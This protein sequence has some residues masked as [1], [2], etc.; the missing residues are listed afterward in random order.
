MRNKPF[1]VD[2][3]MLRPESN[4]RSLANTRDVLAPLSAGR[5]SLANRI[6][7]GRVMSEL[8]RQQ[9]DMVAS[10]LSY[11][12]GRKVEVAVAEECGK[13]LGKAAHNIDRM[14]RQVLNTVGDSIAAHQR[15][16]RLRLHRSHADIDAELRE[17]AAAVQRG[18]LSE[19]SAAMQRQM[20]DWHRGVQFQMNAKL[21][22][23]ATHQMG[24]LAQGCVGAARAALDGLDGGDAALEEEMPGPSTT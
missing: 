5:L 24:L 10:G 12:T 15:D 13:I 21:C 22:D 7:K 2:A 16:T 9:M 1:T 19:E 23:T 6:R 20:L 4:S 18:E 14:N 11:V 17:I 8:Q 3:S